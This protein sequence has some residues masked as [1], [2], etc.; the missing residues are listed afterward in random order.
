MGL[1]SAQAHPERIIQR[2][3]SNRSYKSAKRGATRG[4]WVVK[5]ELV[6]VPPA[7]RIPLRCIRATRAQSVAQ[8][9]AR[10]ER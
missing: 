3:G 8:P 2:T 4:S 7:P 5:R 1:F 10:I 6:G 9:V